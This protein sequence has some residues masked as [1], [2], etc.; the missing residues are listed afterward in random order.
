MQSKGWLKELDRLEKDIRY[1]LATSADAHEPR[2]ARV[3]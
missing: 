1:Y 3:G 2:V